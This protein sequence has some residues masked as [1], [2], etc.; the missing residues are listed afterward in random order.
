MEFNDFCDNKIHFTNQPSPAAGGAMEVEEEKE[1]AEE[2]EMEEEKVKSNVKF[3]SNPDV[4]FYSQSPAVN[5]PTDNIGGKSRYLRSSVRKRLQSL[6]DQ[7][8]Q[9]DASGA[10][11]FGRSC[12]V[13]LDSKKQ[14]NKSVA[15]MVE[16]GAGG[17]GSVSGG[18]DFSHSLPASSFRKA[19]RRNLRPPTPP[20]HQHAVWV[21][22]QKKLT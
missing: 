2:E 18:V 3:D 15:E 22:C 17:G 10:A 9:G 7:G 21:G 1:A 13:L 12:P 16:L 4:N 8:N 11:D 6:V 14:N 20:L 5:I 19:Q